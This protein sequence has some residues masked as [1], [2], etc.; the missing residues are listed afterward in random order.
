MA[1]ICIFA[2]CAGCRQD[3]LTPAK[4]AKTDIPE[5]FKQAWVM[6]SAWCGEMGVAIALTTDQ[7]YYW[8][9][10]DVKLDDEPEYPMTGSYSFVDGKLQLNGSNYFYYATNWI[11]VPNGGRKC[12][13]AERDVGDVARHLIPDAHFDPGRPFQ[14]Q[15]TLEAE[16][17]NAP[18]SSPAAAGSKR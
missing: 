9:Y 16:P 6:S 2:L 12:L 18:Y 14:N 13:S 7:Y 1:F 8:F 3:A 15:G 4:T 11:V 17:A 5:S 10:S